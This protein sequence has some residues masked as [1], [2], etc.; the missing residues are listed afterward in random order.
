MRCA[1][2]QPTY[3]PWS[4]YF[5]LIA[6][7]DVFVFLDN[8]QFE[9]QSWQSRNR[10]LL[11]GREHLLVVPVESAPLSTPICEVVTSENRGNWRSDHLKTLKSAYGKAPYGRQ[12]IELLEPFYSLSAPVELGAF[13]KEIIQRLSHEL[14]L[15]ARFITASNLK[16]TG[17]RTQRLIAIC[18]EVSAST[19]VSPQGSADYLAEDDFSG[20][21]DVSLEIQSFLPSPY[22]QYR[23]NEFISHLSIIDV[24]ANIGLAHASTYVSESLR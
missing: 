5:N 18:K 13:N 2:M 3:L 19:Y 7:V 11:Q 22:R 21:S 12:L 6:L 10:I 23:S 24:I 14:H 9:R 15:P 17:E 20:I 4:G 1:I 16:C 8:V